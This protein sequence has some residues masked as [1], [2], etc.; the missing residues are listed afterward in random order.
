MSA[1][2]IIKNALLV[3]VGVLAGEKIYNTFIA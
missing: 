3:L 1:K 2:V